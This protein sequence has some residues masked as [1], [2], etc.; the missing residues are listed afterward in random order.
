MKKINLKN[1]LWI[2]AAIMAFV[3][4]STDVMAQRGQRNFN[5]TGMRQGN[6]QGLMQNQ[7]N[8]EAAQRCFTMLDLTAEQQAQ[9][10]TMRVKHMEQML[11]MR[12][13]RQEQRAKLQTLR[14]AKNIDMKAI[15]S[16]IDEMADLKANQMK[17]GEVHRQEIRALLTDEQRIL[18]DSFSGKRH[19]NGRGYGMAGRFNGQGN[20]AQRF[21]RGMGR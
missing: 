21:G 8:F 1:K 5:R 9:M 19:G 11:P 4:I 15:N 10:K 12:N 13:Q 6:G 14:T 2:T 17:T 7:R 16:L 20:S 18:F 3:V